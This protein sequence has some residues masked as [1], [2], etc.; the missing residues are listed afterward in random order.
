MKGNFMSASNLSDSPAPARMA[1][2][3]CAPCS[4]EISQKPVRYCDSV[5]IPGAAYC[6]EH[7]EQHDAAAK[8]AKKFSFLAQSKTTAWR[9]RS[10]A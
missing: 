9:I 6:R 1:K 5:A 10:W 2:K 4:W 7:Q 8:R 3:L